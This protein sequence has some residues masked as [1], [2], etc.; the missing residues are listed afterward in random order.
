[1]LK[2]W[3]EAWKRKPGCK[4]NGIVVSHGTRKATAVEEKGRNISCEAVPIVTVLLQRLKITK[5]QLTHTGQEQVLTSTSLSGQTIQS[6]TTLIIQ[7][8]S[9]IATGNIYS[10]W[11]PKPTTTLHLVW[12]L[13]LQLSALLYTLDTWYPFKLHK[14]WIGSKR[15]LGS[16]Y[17]QDS[18][19]SRVSVKRRSSSRHYGLR[20]INFSPQ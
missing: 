10:C 8:V 15:P 12:W 4:N 14:S 5:H 17:E 11:T 1:M 6:F 2:A 16:G 20:I 9:L 3:K 13:T 19:E 7:S 18:S